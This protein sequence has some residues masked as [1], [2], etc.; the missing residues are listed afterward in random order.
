LDKASATGGQSGV[1]PQSPS[2][3]SQGMFWGLPLWGSGV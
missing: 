1:K 3:R 2:R